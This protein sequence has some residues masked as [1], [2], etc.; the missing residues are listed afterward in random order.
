MEEKRRISRRV[1]W[2]V[3]IAVFLLWMLV[4]FV[5]QNNISA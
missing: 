4:A 1:V 2:T 3:L 5:A